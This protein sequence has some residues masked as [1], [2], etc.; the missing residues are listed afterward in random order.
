VCAPEDLTN[1]L[2]ALFA[3]QLAMEVP[4]ASTD[5]IDA[6]LLDSVKFVELLLCLEQRFG[7]CVALDELEIDYFRSVRAIA[8]LVAQ[9][10]AVHG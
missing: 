7:V 3:E 1:E 5:L 9:H 8:A 10:K 6:G 4:S 2:M